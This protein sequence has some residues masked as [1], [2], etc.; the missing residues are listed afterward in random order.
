MGLP[1]LESLADGK[2]RVGG[3]GGHIY[4]EQGTSDCANG[5]GCWAGPS[6]SG[7]PEGVDP[8]G[9]CPNAKPAEGGK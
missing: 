7:G 1:E 4:D 8:L 9:A 5:C 2:Q 3:A 6:R